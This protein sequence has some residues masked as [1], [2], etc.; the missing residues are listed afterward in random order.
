[1]SAGRISKLVAPSAGKRNANNNNC[2]AVVGSSLKRSVNSRNNVL[3]GGQSSTSTSSGLP[4]SGGGEDYVA[5]QYVNGYC[6]QTSSPCSDVDG[7][8]RQCATVTSVEQ[9]QQTVL[10]THLQVC[11]Q[12]VVCNWR[13]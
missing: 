4:R 1:M 8:E 10:A 13:W 9:H 2:A 3:V 11:T 5:V 6:S 7:P 12:C